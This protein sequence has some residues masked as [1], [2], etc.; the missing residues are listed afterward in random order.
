MYVT[1]KGVT[2]GVMKATFLNVYVDLAEAQL[3]YSLTGWKTVFLALT[4][5]RTNGMPEP[6][7]KAF[8]VYIGTLC[9]EKQ[10]DVR[11]M[12]GKIGIDPMELLSMV[13]GKTPLTKAARVGLAK[14][15]GS[16]L[17]YLQKLAAEIS[18]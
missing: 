1:Y 9:V 3:K 5:G 15:L 2:G 18:T 16:D 8:A 12:G 13:N 4:H 11:K 10:T 7:P 14:E 17:A 6:K